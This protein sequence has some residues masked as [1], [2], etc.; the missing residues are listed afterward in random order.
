MVSG[1]CVEFFETD[2]SASRGNS[3]SPYNHGVLSWVVSIF[4]FQGKLQG[5]GSSERLEDEDEWKTF[6]L[7]KSYVSLETFLCCK[8]H[9]ANN[10]S[11]QK[12]ITKIK[13]AST[14]RRFDVVW[15]STT[16]LHRWNDVVCLL[17]SELLYTNNKT[18]I[19]NKMQS[20]VLKK[21]NNK[22]AYGGECDR[23]TMFSS[24]ERFQVGQLAWQNISALFYIRLCEIVQSQPLDFAPIQNVSFARYRSGA[25]ADISGCDLLY[26]R[27]NGTVWVLGAVVFELG[28]HLRGSNA[29]NTVVV[30]EKS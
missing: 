28:H 1:P 16:L 14:R 3:L 4:Q 10:I 2:D 23:E 24:S 21:N 12:K 20:N 13:Q 11:W 6:N 7:L 27:D 8:N 17:G 22:K 18:D 30:G 9:D 5:W 19:G 15:A 29:C 25:C 26:P